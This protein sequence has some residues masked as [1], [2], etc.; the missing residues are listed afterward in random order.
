WTDHGGHQSCER[1]CFGID[2]TSPQ[3]R[4][5][6]AD[7]SSVQGLFND[8]QAL[9]LRVSDVNIDLEQ[10]RTELIVDGRVQLLQPVWKADDMGWQT[11]LLCAEDGGIQVRLSACDRAGNR[12][13]LITERFF[14]DRQAPRWQLTSERSLSDGPVNGSPVGW[15]TVQESHF[16]PDGIRLLPSPGTQLP[17]MGEWQRTAQGYRAALYFL[18]E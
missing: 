9:T 1:I 16:V 3:L 6:F 11:S 12:Q 4:C 13:E 17:M 18:Q 7:G 15:L 2:R 8:P 5:T 10:L 14:I